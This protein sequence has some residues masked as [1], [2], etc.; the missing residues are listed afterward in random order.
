MITKSDL[1]YTI[2]FIYLYSLR[3][4]SSFTV[5]DPARDQLNSYPSEHFNIAFF[6]AILYLII[7]TI[8]AFNHT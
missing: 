2:I 6:Y 8:Y 1:L 5:F 4:P 7:Y 3:N